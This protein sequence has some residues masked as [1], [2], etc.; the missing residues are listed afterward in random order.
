[1]ELE[2]EEEEGTGRPGCPSKC[3]AR[4]GRSDRFGK[5]REQRDGFSEVDDRK[6]GFVQKQKLNRS[7]EASGID[8]S[9]RFDVLSMTRHESETVEVRSPLIRDPRKACGRCD[10]KESRGQKHRRRRNWR[11]PMAVRCKWKET[12]NLNSFG[13]ARNAA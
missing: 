2:E 10:T 4:K 13:L 3:W 9:N 12:R 6:G 8:Q 7:N 11:Q 5:I 1:M